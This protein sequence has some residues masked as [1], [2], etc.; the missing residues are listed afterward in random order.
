MDFIKVLGVDAGT[1]AVCDA[2]VFPEDDNDAWMDYGRH[3]SIMGGMAVS[4]TGIGDGG[5]E[6]F[7]LADGAGF[8]VVFLA[9]DDV[10]EQAQYEAYCAAGAHYPGAEV[11]ELGVIGAGTDLAFGD[12]CYGHPTATVLVE[13]GRWRVVQYLADLGDW[14]TRVAKLGVYPVQDASAV[15]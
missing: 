10:E 7:R 3:G 8:E 11:K 6:L 2:K 9:P 15:V 4:S 12:P 13:P 5:Y 14:G 1:M